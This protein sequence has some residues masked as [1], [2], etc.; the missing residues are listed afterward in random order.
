MIFTKQSTDSITTETNTSMS[1]N[2]LANASLDE[3]LEFYRR[4]DLED[5]RNMLEGTFNA[6]KEEEATGNITDGL[7]EYYK[8]LCDIII[9]TV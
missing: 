4:K 9:D 7:I 2:D 1:D 6:I 8:L 3:L 5:F